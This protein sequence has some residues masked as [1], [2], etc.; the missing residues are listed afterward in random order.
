MLE[1]TALELTNEYSDLVV[2][3]VASDYHTG[4]AEVGRRRDR[5]KGFLFMGSN[6]G[7]FER[8]DAEK[9][10]ADIRSAMAPNDLLLLGVD[11]V[12]PVEMLLAAYDD[13]AGVTRAFNMNLLTRLNREVGA[14]F[15]LEQFEHVA[16]W[17]VASKAIQTYL[18]SRERQTVTLSDLNIEVTFEA[19]EALHTESS[20]KYTLEGVTRIADSAGLKLTQTWTDSRNWFA[21]NLLTAS[22]L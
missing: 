8:S 1:R 20:H 12:K 22:N 2:E 14:N 18:V 11:L 7:N 4:L 10:L 21:L 3:A 5:Q 16:R 9:F 15:N 13:A 17:N 6:L 19:A